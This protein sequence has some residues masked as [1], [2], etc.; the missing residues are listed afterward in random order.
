MA[1]HIKLITRYF[2][3]G[4]YKSKSRGFFFLF[5]ENLIISQYILRYSIMSIKVYVRQI[6]LVLKTQ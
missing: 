1:D 2:N 5:H 3:W 4:H 6:D